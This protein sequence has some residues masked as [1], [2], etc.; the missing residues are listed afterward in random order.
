M[1]TGWSRDGDVMVIGWARDGHEKGTGWARD[2][3]GVTQ[4]GHGVGTGGP[5]GGHRVVTAAGYHEVFRSRGGRTGCRSPCLCERASVPVC[6]RPSA[7][8]LPPFS[9]SAA[10]PA[11]TSI[12]CLSLALSRRSPRIAPAAST[13]PSAG[14]RRPAQPPPPDPHRR[15]RR[16]R[17]TET[18]AAAKPVRSPP[19]RWR[20]W[21]LGRMAKSVGIAFLPP[22]ADTLVSTA[23]VPAAPRQGRRADRMSRNRMENLQVWTA[24]KDAALC[25]L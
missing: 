7:A 25:E 18:A 3:H 6:L 12:S 19:P 1:V 13:A 20:P 4:R 24:V 16:R 15:S 22:P 11:C 2:G 21:R 14:H 5:R 10:A 17:E 23:A 9:P 8:R